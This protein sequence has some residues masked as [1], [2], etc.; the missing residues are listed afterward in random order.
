LAIGPVLDEAIRL[1]RWPR[2]AKPEE[3]VRP[4]QAGRRNAVHPMVKEDCRA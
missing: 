1:D 4:N 2:P 3:R